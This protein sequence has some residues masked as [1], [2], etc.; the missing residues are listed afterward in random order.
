MKTERYA[1]RFTYGKG[2]HRMN[3]T[4]PTTVTPDGPQNIHHINCIM[5]EL[6]TGLAFGCDGG[7]IIRYCVFDDISRTWSPLYGYHATED[8]FFKL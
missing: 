3:T 8:R 6:G 2:H 7:L 1:F 5:S 4:I